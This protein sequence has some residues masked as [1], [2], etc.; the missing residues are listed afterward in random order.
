MRLQG[1]FSWLWVDDGE[2]RI[3][4]AT[5]LEAMESS[6]QIGADL[7]SGEVIGTRIS[8]RF[9]QDKNLDTTD[10][11]SCLMSIFLRNMLNSLI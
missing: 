11:F 5:D 1:W 6:L 3:T 10:T 9:F 4:S 8:Y 2:R 7:I